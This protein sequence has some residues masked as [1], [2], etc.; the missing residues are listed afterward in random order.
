MEDILIKTDNF[1]ISFLTA[2][3]SII[4]SHLPCGGPICKPLLTW[5]LLK[6]KKNEA[7]RQAQ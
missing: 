4:Y 2:T 7:Y 5:K 6:E 3:I 1:Y